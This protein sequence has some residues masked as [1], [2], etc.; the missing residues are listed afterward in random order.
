MSAKVKFSAVI[1][2]ETFT[3]KAALQKK[4]QA[5]LYRYN[6]DDFLSEQDL[7]FMVD[8]LRLHPDAIIKIGCGVESIQVRQNPIYRQSRGF[9]VVRY[10][11]SETDFSYL[12]CLKET[13]HHHRFTRACR[14][15]I[16][17][18][19]AQA[20]RKFFLERGGRI[21]NC[22]ITREII[23]PDNCHVDHAA[24]NTFKVILSSF[25]SETGLDISS[26]KVNGNGED[27]VL[28]DTLD[29]K[30]LEAKWVEYHN[31]RA[32]LQVVSRTA[33]LSTLRAR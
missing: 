9:W 5:I 7:L 22:P 12:E 29:D 13:P 18:Y 2:G 11:G 4:I 32:V 3:T 17:P 25:V 20:R 24:P 1:C 16:E 19:I 27:G 33:N 23:T 30:T 31:A 21:A 28:Q 10:D 14:V 8:V 26:V 15:A 6:N